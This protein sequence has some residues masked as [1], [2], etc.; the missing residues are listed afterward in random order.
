MSVAP[1][2][3][4]DS[5]AASVTTTARLR[6]FVALSEFGSIR[7][8]AHRMYV[9]ES[10]V[11]AAISALSTDVGVALIERRGRGVQLTP[12]GL[13]FVGYARKI[14]GLHEEALRAARGEVSPG[15]GAVRLAA[16][17]TAAE[18]VL[19]K[20]LVRFRTAHPDVAIDLNV[21]TREQIWP[22]LSNH[23]VDVVIAG[24]PPMDSAFAV[25]ALR[26]NELIA[27]AAAELAASFTVE[28]TTWLMREK[29]SGTRETCEAMLV[30]A[31]ADPPRL[32]L[33]SNGAVVAGAV[34]GLG[35]TLVS[36]DAVCDHL[37]RGTLVELEL[38]GVSLTRPWHAVTQH[39][40]SA[41][42][43]LFIRFL[44]NTAASDES[45]AWAE[46]NSR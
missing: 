32:T 20:I 21:V 14:L 13:I 18:H 33:G 29:G 27:V 11:S 15:Q 45:P 35:V 3:H 19:P 37:A 38:P 17:T 23:E 24:R 46:P 43:K 1:R 16:V 40:I 36:R 31:E 22:M 12:A 8:A 2:W 44:L 34:A 28:R 41:P 39:R 30:N 5:P 42:T 6:A 26:S 10:S 4:A 7:A 25:R 9:T